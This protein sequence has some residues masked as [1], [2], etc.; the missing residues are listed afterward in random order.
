M[1]TPA[2]I[3]IDRGIE[4]NNETRFE[5]IRVNSDGHPEHTLRILEKH[6]NT[7]DSL[8][9]L[10]ALGELSSLDV[11][12]DCPEGHNF[13]NRVKGYS[14]AYGRD[15][16]EYEPQ[17]VSNDVEDHIAEHYNYIFRVDANQWFTHIQG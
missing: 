13:D 16:G 10:I 6:Y 7:S 1:G 14:V 2:I 17:V 4:H 11:S 3:I 5:S 12:A 9:E 8:E 15:R